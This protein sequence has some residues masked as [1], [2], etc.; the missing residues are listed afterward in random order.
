[1]DQIVLPAR[2]IPSFRVSE[3]RRRGVA[4][5]LLFTTWGG[6][7]DQLCA[8]PTL[9]F[10]LDTFKNC[11]VSLATAYPE[12]FTHLNFVKVYNTREEQPIKENY[13]VFDTIPDPS[14]LSFEFFSHSVTHCVDYPA[15]SSLRCTLPI[16]YKSVIQR[17]IVS[18]E[19]QKHLSQFTD[20]KYVAI[21]AGK[22]WQSKTFPKW[23]WDEV[24]SELIRL[25]F[26]PVLFGKEID[27]TQ[28]TVD[29]NPYRCIDLRNILSLSESI[30]LLQRMNSMITND[31]SPLHMAA[32]GKAHIAFVASAKHQDYIYH[33]RR[34]PGVEPQ[35]A[36]RMQHFNS[37]GIWDLLSHCPN[38]E[39]SV[40][41]DK[42]DE[43]I[44]ESW[45]PE[46]E[47]IVQW[48][49]LRS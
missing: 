21:H 37:G 19:T 14:R 38:Q 49:R 28:G 12:L 43:K 2:E 34:E 9:R 7:G 35:W 13:L 1:M 46:T 16:S 42:V 47:E 40:L 29:V 25:E 23:W 30:W 41:I 18:E 17:P 48:I 26:V 11:N 31:S 6:I 36:W 15:I 4:D 39:E 32:T 24:L 8:E 5:N 22:H 20:K 3:A 10:A 27:E 33:W 45:L 44:L